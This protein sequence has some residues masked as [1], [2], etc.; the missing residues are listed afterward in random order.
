MLEKKLSWSHDNQ[1]SLRMKRQSLQ[2]CECPICRTLVLSL[3]DK[4]RGQMLGFC[5]GTTQ[6]S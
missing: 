5:K 3:A 4:L 1:V 2:V 6:S